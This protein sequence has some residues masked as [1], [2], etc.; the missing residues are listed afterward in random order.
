MKSAFPT[1]APAPSPLASGSRRAALKA[2]SAGLTVAGLLSTTRLAWAAEK[3][4]IGYQTSSTLLILLKRNGALD[5]KLA[6]LG[7]EVSW[8]ELSSGLLTTLNTGGVDIHADVADAFALFTQAAGAPLTYYAK[9]NAAPTAQAIVVPDNSNIKTVADLK[10]RKVAVMK[11]TGSNFLLLNALKKVGLSTQ[12]IDVRYLEAPAAQAAFAGGSVDAWVI[13]DPVLA[14]VQR[15][16]KVRA[17][18]SG[19]NGNAP[20][21]RFFMANT[22][23]A[24]KHPEVLALLFK[25]LREVGQWVKANPK[26]AA[27]I[28]GPAWGNVDPAIVELANQRRSYDIVPVRRNELTEQQRIADTFFEAGL[29]PKKLSTQDIKIWSAS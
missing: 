10:G 27:D 28:L 11:G 1:L 7:F 16:G 2:L 21:Y 22:A 12:D 20:Y 26:A 8:H 19:E 5:K 18:A 6:E 25:E 9:E 17:I 14:T 3:L 15:Q 13:W 4:R 24:D 29:I 23:F